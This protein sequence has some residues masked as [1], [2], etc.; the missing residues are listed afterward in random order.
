LLFD[1]TTVSEIGEQAPTATASALVASVP[2]ALQ[3]FTSTATL[4][5]PFGTGNRVELRRK[6]NRLVHLNYAIRGYI[7][8]GALKM[9]DENWWKRLM[10]HLLLHEEVSHEL[11]V[12]LECSSVLDGKCIRPGPLWRPYGGVTGLPIAFIHMSGSPSLGA[13]E[14]KS[15]RTV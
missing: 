13:R 2:A 1:E 8:Q 7:I 5:H 6:L 14:N 3:A 11:D 9:E 10:K 12:K 15:W 4:S